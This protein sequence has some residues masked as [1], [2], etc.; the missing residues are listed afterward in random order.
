ML[1]L[2]T[3]SPPRVLRRFWAIGLEGRRRA[4][5]RGRQPLKK[6]PWS[7]PPVARGDQAAA[8]GARV[9]PGKGR[10]AADGSRH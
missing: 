9:D 10:G 2:A 4:I 8:Q 3:I 6:G 1:I 7:P 5:A